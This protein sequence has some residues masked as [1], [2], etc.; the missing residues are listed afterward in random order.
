MA[1]LTAPAATA[2]SAARE[3]ARTYAIANHDR[4]VAEL[5]A[6]VRFP[7]VSAQPERA[8]DL[9]R[10][11]RWLAGHLSRVGLKRATVVTT[12]GHPAVYADWLHAPGRPTILVYGHYDVVP[13]EPLDEWHS[14]PFAPMVRGQHL[15]GRG[16]S[17]DKGQFLA[18]VKAVESYLRT[19][20]ALPVNV[21]FLLDGE[22]EIGSPHLEPV[23]TANLRALAADAA[24]VSD[25]RI[26]AIDRP[27]ITY[28]TRGALAVELEVRG[29]AADLHAGIFG[30]A[31]HNPLQALCEL[32][33]KLHGPGGR[34][35]VPGFYDQ[36]VPLP[37]RERAYLARTGPSDRAILASA[38]ADRGCGEDGWTLY[39]R[40]TARPSLTVNGLTGGY[41]GP[42]AKAVIPAVATAKLSF[43]LV[44]DQ[45]PV[46]I[47]RLFRH[48]LS[49]L[50]P[51]TVRWAL[52]TGLHAHPTT[53]DTQHPVVAAA[54]RAYRAGYG[55]DSVLVRSG[56]TL[57]AAGVLQD[58]L[59]IPTV[60]MGFAL[61]DD[62]TH[63]PDERFHLTSFGRGVATS[64]AFLAEIGAA[65]W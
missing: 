10:C 51:P 62:R 21:V 44:P 59:G 14:P 56:G 32:I 50:T 33:A 13:A 18:H 34:V 25:T 23:L 2:G 9:R 64:I 38:G 28:A 43:R 37:D 29:P 54:A 4:F 42:G 45:D 61:P 20:G 26:L 24:V 40:S 3:A 49:A 57:P 39:E 19:T 31:V 60:L 15:Y 53:L 27:A 7:T 12:P 36:V 35:T 58:R 16:V 5:Q 52:R 17:D 6:L 46:E 41:Q 1:Q 22:E 63:A 11:A 30:G 47:A 48:H 8:L 65:P 55:A